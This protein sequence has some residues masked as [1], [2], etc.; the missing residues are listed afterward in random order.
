MAFRQTW[1]LFTL[2]LSFTIFAGRDAI[3]HA[4]S[5]KRQEIYRPFVIEISEAAIGSYIIHLA[6][7]TIAFILV[8]LL[9]VPPAPHSQVTE[10][11]FLEQQSKPNEKVKSQH[12]QSLKPVEASGKHDPKKLITASALG[13]HSE[14]ANVSQQAMQPIRP[15]VKPHP[16]PRANPSEAP[17]AVPT[18]LAPLPKADLPMPAKPLPKAALPAVPRPAEAPQRPVPLPM[19]IA[20]SQM[21]AAPI[22]TDLTPTATKPTQIMPEPAVSRHLPSQG[23]A[24]APQP[25]V[26]RSLASLPSADFTRLRPSAGD[27]GSAREG[28]GT[29]QE[30]PRPQADNQVETGQDINWAPYMADLQRRIKRS[31]FPPPNTMSRRVVVLFKIHQDGELSDLRIERSS[32]LPNCDNAALKAVESAAP[33]RPLPA[34]QK[35]PVDIQFTFD[36][37]VFNGGNGT[38]FKR[39]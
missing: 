13:S 9:I 22:A 29:S 12:Y 38:S 21:A 6:F 37:N 19:P 3:Q 1:I 26:P 28:V 32:S 5:M 30:N 14:K 2:S 25:T 27:R 4:R 11:Q 20:H 7:V 24:S 23:S 16:T 33:F 36:Y 34:G 39:F 31:W 18:P 10:I 15:I 35:G 8:F 17:P